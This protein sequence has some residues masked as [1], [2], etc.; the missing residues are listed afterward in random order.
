MCK[1]GRGGAECSNPPQ[2]A[3][4]GGG[5]VRE[6]EKKGGKGWINWDMLLLEQEV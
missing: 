4:R 6:R 1:G 3:R 5:A 2:S